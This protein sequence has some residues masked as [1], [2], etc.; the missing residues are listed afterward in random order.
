HPTIDLFCRVMEQFNDGE[1]R[2]VLKLV[3]PTPRSPLLGFGTL[4]P[5]LSI[6]DA[7]GDKERLPSTSTCENLLK[8]PICKD[9][10]ALK[11]KLLYSV[12]SEAGVSI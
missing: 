12:L 3:T 11:E 4:H 9:E 8:L 10:S 7:G 2:A 1:R 5:P 6:R